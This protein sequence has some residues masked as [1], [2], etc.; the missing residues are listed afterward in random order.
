MRFTRV[1]RSAS[2]NV[3]EWQSA[4]EAVTFYERQKQLRRP[5]SLVGPAVHWQ[6]SSS[7]CARAGLVALC[8]TFVRRC[9]GGLGSPGL[10][11]IDKSS[12]M[13]GEVRAAWDVG[14]GPMPL[15]PAAVIPELAGSLGGTETQ[16]YIDVSLAS[17][18]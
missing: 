2:Q 10:P 11:G 18:E 14:R 15:I 3:A 17:G 5:L 8:Q 12:M 4:F 9:H 1:P 16:F 7:S 6:I 13:A